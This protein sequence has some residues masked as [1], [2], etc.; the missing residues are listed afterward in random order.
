MISQ[1]NS[2][3]DGKKINHIFHT[4]NLPH[5]EILNEIHLLYMTNYAI[6]S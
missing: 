5:V 2:L 6:P 3:S 1:L 4:T